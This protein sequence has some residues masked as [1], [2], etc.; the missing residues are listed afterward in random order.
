MSSIDQARRDLVADLAAVSD[1]PQLEADQL[2]LEALGQTEAAFLYAN[3]E[4]TLSPTA[5]GSLQE[6]VA[7]RLTGQPLAYV[8]GRLD[9]YG[10]TF[11]VTEDVLVP[12][13][14]TE[15]VVDRALLRIGALAEALD[16]HL[17]VADVGTGSGVIAITLVLEC[18]ARHIPL[19]M[20]AT[21]IS[22]RALEVAAR[23]AAR[24]G[25][26]DFITFRQGDMLEPLKGFAID[27][28][29]SNPPYVPTDEL[30]KT[31][32]QATAALRFEPRAALDGGADGQTFIQ[33]ITASSIP[34]VIEG[35]G[36]E[37]LES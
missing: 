13:P 26:E 37:I 12:R 27:L 22:A 24:H 9:F 25:V 8:L 32:S 19:N 30:D 23:N 16:S 29:V 15:D 21:D 14:R 5:I 17:W 36:G 34:A 28:I 10:R 35:V 20:L 18:L 3:G 33:Q 11:E 31:P 1:A 2:L 6:L 7:Q 4:A